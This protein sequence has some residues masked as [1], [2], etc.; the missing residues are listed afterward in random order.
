MH[1]HPVRYPTDLT[2]EE[3]D[4][5]KSLVPTAKSGK[6]TRGRPLKLERRQLVSAILYLVRSGCAWRL[7]HPVYNRVLGIAQQL[8]HARA[9][10]T[11]S[12]E[13]SA[14]EPMIIARCVVGA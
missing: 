4:Y 9:C 14:V 1:T 10:H 6:G 11:L 13:R 5:I 7:L 3:W 8:R 2:D 12:H